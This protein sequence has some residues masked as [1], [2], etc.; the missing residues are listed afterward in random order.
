MIFEDLPILTR[1]LYL[2]FDVYY[3][4]LKSLLISPKNRQMIEDPNEKIGTTEEVLFWTFE[5]YCSGLK[6][7]TINLLQEISDY[8]PPE[9][10]KIMTKLFQEFRDLMNSSAQ[11]VE[12]SLIFASTSFPQNSFSVDCGGK[13]PGR[14]EEK[15]IL[16]ANIV[17]NLRHKI[18]IYRKSKNSLRDSSEQS[19]EEDQFAIACK[20]KLTF[21]PKIRSG[22]SVNSPK[23][24]C[25]VRLFSN[26]EIFKK[27]F[28]FSEI[29]HYNVLKTCC[30]YESY[31]WDGND[32]FSSLDTENGSSS[33]L[34]LEESIDNQCKKVTTIRKE[35]IESMYNGK[36]LYFCYNTPIWRE[37]IEKYKGKVN[38]E[39]KTIEFYFAPQDIVNR[40]NEKFFYCSGDAST[41]NVN[42]PSQ[43]T[44][45]GSS[46]TL[47]S[48]ESLKKSIEID[49]ED[50]F[51]ALYDYEPDNNMFL[52]EWIVGK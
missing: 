14:I 15:Y 39:K 13:S 48:E 44:V 20:G 19:V 31:K 1:Y 18:N 17:E 41:K 4:L 49:F 5:L 26:N 28:I 38:H 50:E 3:S 10:D 29:K 40:S 34:H 23:K 42:L 22:E 8:Y 43:T 32:N 21:S 47:Q 9:N 16:I 7:E 36:W 37:R 45:N 12:K 11:S 27:L 52:I 35:V 6:D 46:S 24:R 51:N 33:M 25:L 2:S 30:L